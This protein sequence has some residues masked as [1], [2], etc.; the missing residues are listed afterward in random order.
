MSL[1]LKL[2]SS[3]AMTFS[4]FQLLFFY[5]YILHH[6]I[7]CISIHGDYDALSNVKN[8]LNICFIF[9]LWVSD[10]DCFLSTDKGQR[11][12]KHTLET[13]GD[14][15]RERNRFDISLINPSARKPRLKRHCNRIRITHNAHH[16]HNVEQEDVIHSNMPIYTDLT[17]AVPC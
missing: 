3:N 9:L 13:G 4:H 5:F 17:S 15:E 16:G 14:K 7:F 1:I 6:S 11:G 10:D 2:L 8:K 12:W